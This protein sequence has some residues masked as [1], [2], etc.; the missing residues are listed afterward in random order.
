MASSWVELEKREML[1]TWLL[2]QQMNRHDP[3]ILLSSSVRGSVRGRGS[4]SGN[5]CGNRVMR[6]YRCTGTAHRTTS[7]T[8]CGAGFILGPKKK[9]LIHQTYFQVISIFNVFIYIFTKGFIN[10]LKKTIKH[11]IIHNLLLE[12]YK[13][14]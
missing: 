10:V 14:L 13:K 5:I 12:T 7:K 2:N 8:G 9:K 3:R 6:R 11:F 4:W 1:S